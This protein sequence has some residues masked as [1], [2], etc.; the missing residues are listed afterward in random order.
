MTEDSNKNTSQGNRSADPS[1][2]IDQ[3]QIYHSEIMKTGMNEN[4]KEWWQD[5]STFDV[6][7]KAVKELM[8]SG[9]DRAEQQ[10]PSSSVAATH[11][12]KEK[13]LGQG[14]TGPSIGGPD[15]LC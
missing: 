3:P 14:C 4:N 11:Q 5:N 15:W 10:P 6:S 2:S 7:Y 1:V 9:K 8:T 12:E 13:W